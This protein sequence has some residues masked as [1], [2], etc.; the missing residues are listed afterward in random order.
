[1]K[2]SR[3]YA[4]SGLTIRKNK[5]IVNADSAKDYIFK[6]LGR[7]DYPQQYLTGKLREKGCPPQ[8]VSQ[9][10][11]YFKKQDLINDKKFAYAYARKRVTCKPRGMYLLDH[12]LQDKGIDKFLRS[13]VIKKVYSEKPEEELIKQVVKKKY[14]KILRHREFMARACRF[15]MRRGFSA[16]AISSV[17]SQKGNFNE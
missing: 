17:F 9:V 2:I 11:R 12:E 14:G 6:L 10:I 8:I 15:L 5:D 16:Q 3:R 7:R 1:M 13:E 4:G